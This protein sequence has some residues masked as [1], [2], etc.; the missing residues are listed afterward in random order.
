MDRKRLWVDRLSAKRHSADNFTSLPKW[1]IFELSVDAIPAF[2]VH[3]VI[4]SIMEYDTTQECVRNMIADGTAIPKKK[5]FKTLSYFVSCAFDKTVAK[6]E[7]I[8]R[9]KA[10]AFIC[11]V[12]GEQYD[13]LG[14]ES[15]MYV[16]LGGTETLDFKFN[17]KYKDDLQRKK[18]KLPSY[19]YQMVRLDDDAM[20]ATIITD[21]MTMIETEKYELLRALFPDRCIE[22]APVWV[23]VLVYRNEHELDILM[24]AEALRYPFVNLEFAELLSPPSL[25]RALLLNA[26]KTLHCDAIEYDETFLYDNEDG[27]SFLDVVTR[28][29]ETRQ[30]DEEQATDALNRALIR[31]SECS[32]K[33]I[34]ARF[35]K[36]IEHFKTAF[37]FALKTRTS[38]LQ[39]RPDPGE[40][41][42]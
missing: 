12:R 37:G 7:C 29:F 34:H 14:N 19:Y 20:L 2:K 8:G 21:D 28:M 1:M 4:L 26:L 18:G 42:G 17:L 23:R 16:I 36:R 38:R 33:A 15:H 32:D 30:L 3:T 22:S 10:V 11:Q 25:K 6:L 41:S 9:A 24:D 13:I 35:S 5:K 27:I 39:R 40:K 31:S